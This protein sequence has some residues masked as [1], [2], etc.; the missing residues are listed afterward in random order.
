MSLNDPGVVVVSMAMGRKQDVPG[1]GHPLV[2]CRSGVRPAIPPAQDM[3]VTPLPATSQDQLAVH[4]GGGGPWTKTSWSF[5]ASSPGT[6]TMPV[7]HTPS[8]KSGSTDMRFTSLPSIGGVV[9]SQ[10]FPGPT[11]RLIQALHA[12]DT[13]VGFVPQ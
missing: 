3:V 9:V 4:D 11:F 10:V 6:P 7:D 2:V 8:G 13:V 12:V 5:A 1:D